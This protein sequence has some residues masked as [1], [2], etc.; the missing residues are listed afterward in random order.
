M[1][2]LFAGLLLIHG[3]IHLMG[4][5]KALGYAE[6]PQLAQPISRPLGFLWLLA[7]VFLLATVVALYAWPRGWWQA[8]LLALVVS[9]AVIITSWSDARFGT[10]ANVLILAG[11]IHGF[12][13]HGP[14]SYRAQFETDVTTALSR[15]GSEIFLTEADVAELPAVL[16]KYIARSGAIGQ[17]RVRNFHLTFDGRIRSGP[18]APWMAFTGEQY[19]TIEPKARFFML[20]ASMRGVPVEVFHRFTSGQA[21][22]RVKAIAL[23]PVLAAQGPEM[24]TAETVTLFNDMCV[25]APGSL[26]DPGIQ[27]GTVGDRVV[28]G[29]FT[30]AGITV[31]ALLT[32]NDAFELVDFVSN[33]RLAGSSD[34][35]SFTAMRW[36]TPLGDYASFGSHYLS[37]YGTGRWHPRDAPPYDYIQLSLRS[38][39]YNLQHLVR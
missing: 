12:A 4:F 19:N 15:P 17:P 27:W 38:I 22:M 9:Q 33:D 34:G 31:R 32:F 20:D 8:G 16:R 28:E 29:T 11:V 1:K 24:T 3:L 13:A 37:G 5:A 26:V 21:T 39:G 35:K 36:S 25:F 7:C 30:N 10:L 6:L 18:E 2:A 14:L 23:V